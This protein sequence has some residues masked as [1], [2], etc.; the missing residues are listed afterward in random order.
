MIMIIYKR[1]NEKSCILQ[2]REKV[3]REEEERKND[4]EKWTRDNKGKGKMNNISPTNKG[5]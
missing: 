2:R 5:W 4:F 1:D 3:M